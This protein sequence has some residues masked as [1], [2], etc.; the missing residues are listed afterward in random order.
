[1]ALNQLKA[2]A[3]L[4]YIIIALNTIVGL[5]YTPVMLRLMGQNEYGLYSLVASVIAYL[6]ILDAG[7]GNAVI[8]YTSKYKAEKKEKELPKMYGMFFSLYTIAALLGLVVGMVLYGNVDS[9]FDQT[10]VGEELRKVRIMMILMVFNLVVTFPMSIWGAIITAHEKFIFLRI[11]NIVRIILNPIVMIIMLLQ[12]YGAIG[13]VV[14]TTIFNITTLIINMIYCKQKL[15]IKIKFSKVEKGLP[16]E[17]IIFSFW[18]FLNAIMDRIYWSTG[19]FVLGMFHGATVVAVYAVAIQ[20]Q[21]MYMQFSTAISGVFLPKVTAMVAKSNNKEEIS[22]LFIRTGR[23]QYIVL[24]FILT[25]F[26]LFGKQFVKL[27]AG[28]SYIEAYY[29]TLLFFVC[30][31]VPLIQNLGITILQA[32]NQMKFRSV[33]YVF[34]AIASLGISIPLAKIYGVLG[35]AIGV[36]TAL[37][38]GQIIIMNI[39]Y[40]KKIQLNIICFWKE[41]A[42]MSIVPIILCVLS[43]IIIS[44]LPE[45][46]TVSGLSLAIALFSLVYIPCFWI[47][48]MNKY[49]RQLFANPVK[50]FFVR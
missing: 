23:I 6:T 11:V 35:P 9:L 4:S 37:V 16:K 24:S 30:L 3:F 15:N 2:G 20:L 5:V 18:I 38:L 41:I 50:R 14:I 7:F 34:I 33:L 1:M 28:E 26:I 32:R 45:I 40:Q 10:M 46:A 25:G 13:M 42:S 17:V 48:S 29:V 47:K 8:R 39:Y 12:G 44:H 36:S 31:T 21:H 19:Q 22:D 43:W 49:E 27:W